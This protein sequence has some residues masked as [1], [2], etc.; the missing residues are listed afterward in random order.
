MTARR[1]HP[2]PPTVVAHPGWDT[3]YVEAADGLDVIESVDG[4]LAWAN[5]FIA[6]MQP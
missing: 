2:W 6:W 3:I 4:A 5:E 1:G